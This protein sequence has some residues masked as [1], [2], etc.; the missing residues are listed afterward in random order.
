MPATP[1]NGGDAAGRPVSFR[2]PDDVLLAGLAFEPAGPPRGAVLLSPAT[3]APKEFY[4]HYAAHLASRG[5]L[6][7]TYDY[8][9]IGGSRPRSLRGF[10]ARMRDWGRLDMT[11]A[12]DEL[13]RLSGGAPLFLLG[14]SVGAQL[15]GLID[16][17]ERFRAVVSVTASVGYWRWMKGS[18]RWYCAALWYGWVPVTTAL[19]GYAPARAVGQGEDL[20]AGI[21]RDWSRWCRTPGYFGDHLGAEDLALFGRVRV[22]WLS[23]AFTDDPISNERTVPP[24]LAFYPNARVESRMISP[25][26]FG[27]PAVGHLG[28]FLARNAGPL[29]DVPIAHF[30]AARDESPRAAAGA[31]A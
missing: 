2:T 8:R 5:F 15:A 21:V 28:F 27:R 20:P 4:R 26:E 17:V 18:Y 1:A 25:S 30:E 16:G 6:V 9:G 7:L 10:P 14:H 29:W 13:E 11:A 3:G 31:R 24:L 19:L 12:L 23:L 22:P